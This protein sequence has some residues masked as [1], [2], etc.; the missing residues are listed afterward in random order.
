MLPAKGMYHADVK[1]R[2]TKLK[3]APNKALA[4]KLTSSLLGQAEKHEKG[5]GEDIAKELNTRGGC[6]TNLINR[7]SANFGGLGDAWE[8]IFGEKE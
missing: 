8:R 6:D 5:A 1:R 4:N 2:I 7:K 3:S